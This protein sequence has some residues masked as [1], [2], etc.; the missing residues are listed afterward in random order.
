MPDFP[1]VTTEVVQQCSPVSHGVNPPILDCATK[2]QH[3]QTYRGSL[4]ATKYYLKQFGKNA[5][6]G[7]FLYPSDIASAKTGFEG[8]KIMHELEQ[9]S[10]PRPEPPS[11]PEV[12]TPA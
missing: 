9:P 12:K 2:D 3:P 1:I 7:V 8:E 10:K 6:H 5:L 11:K 4:G